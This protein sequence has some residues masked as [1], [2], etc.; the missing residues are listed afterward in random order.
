MRAISVAS[1]IRDCSR[2]IGGRRAIATRDHQGHGQRNKVSHR[3]HP[4]DVGV[5]GQRRQ[6]SLGEERLADLFTE[7]VGVERGPKQDLLG[8]G[9][10]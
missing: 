6:R 9:S 10:A 8:R 5:D 2:P 7:Q 4:F 1:R 3:Q